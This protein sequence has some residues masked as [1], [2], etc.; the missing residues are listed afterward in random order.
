MQDSGHLPV[1]TWSAAL[2]EVTQ[3][4]IIQMRPKSIS[5]P[6]DL[7]EEVPEDLDDIMA[8]MEARDV[9]DA[10]VVVEYERDIT[11]NQSGTATFRDF[12]ENSVTFGN[13]NPRSESN[14]NYVPPFSFSE[15]T[16]LAAKMASQVIPSTG[17]TPAST[18]AMGAIS[19]RTTTPTTTTTTKKKKS[20]IVTKRVTVEEE[21]VSISTKF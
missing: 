19:R 4:Q 15:K 8:S 21:T 10:D 17:N 16:K 9:E 3:D 13:I 20:K 18:P 7:E 1:L 6:T 11:T 14:N 12:P 2:K 5:W